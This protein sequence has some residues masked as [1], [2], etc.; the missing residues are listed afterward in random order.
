MDSHLLARYDRPVPRYTSY[1][2]APHFTPAVGA[3]AYAAWLRGVPVEAPLSLYVHIPFCDSLCWFCGCHMRVVNRYSSI[4]S[5]LEVLHREIDLVA[6]ALPGRRAAGHLHFGGGSPDILKPSDAWSLVFHLR[7]A[8]AF[9]RDAELAV[10]IDPRAADESVIK[11]WAAAG[12]TRASIGVQ[13]FDPQVQQAINRAQSFD[14]TKRAI[15]GLRAAGVDRINID[16]LYGL[17][18][19]SA[20]SVQRTVE[21]VV[22]LAP[23]RIALFGYA[24]V[25]WLK[26]HQRLIDERA[27]PDGAQRWAQFEAAAIL[28]RA[29]GYL[30]IGLDHFAK[31]DDPLAVASATGRLHRNFQGYTTDPCEALIGFGATAIG[32][33]PQGYVQNAAGIN[34]YARSIRDDHLPIARGIALTDDDRRRRAIIERLMCELRVDLS[35]YGGADEFSA[36][37][38]RLD[39]MVADGLLEHDGSSI[40][41]TERGRP[42]MRAVCAVFDRYLAAG[43]GRHSRAV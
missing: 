40:V 16:L 17:P 3:D 37:R 24:H 13:D 38:G 22:T 19:Q 41:I 32:A 42:F 34:D 15:D 39:G 28:M 35:I 36:E 31:P 26:T 2:T 1:P 29:A 20:D 25:P 5:Y 43:T 10:E 7:D 27:L 21:Q 23:D 4:R 33:L 14:C 8:F 12:A 30:W 11:A 18:H 6:G 9:A